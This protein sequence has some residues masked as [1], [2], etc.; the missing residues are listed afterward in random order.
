MDMKKFYYIF[1]YD[2]IGVKKFVYS[3]MDFFCKNMCVKKKELSFN[4]N[5]NSKLHYLNIEKNIWNHPCDINEK[6]DLSFFELYEMAI[7]RAVNIINSVDNM[8]NKKKIDNKKLEKLFGNFDY[9][10]GKDCCLELKYKY[11]KF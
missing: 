3:V 5:P 7:D 11:F 8:L 4:V 10:T 1:N 9:G 2:K 6:Y